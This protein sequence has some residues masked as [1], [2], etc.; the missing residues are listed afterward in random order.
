MRPVDDQRSRHLVTVS[1]LCMLTSA[2]CFSNGMVFAS[3]NSMYPIHLTFAPQWSV[4]PYSVS[5]TQ[6]PD[7]SVDVTVTAEVEG[8]MFRGF[9]L[10][11][12]NS[13]NMRAGSFVAVPPSA[14]ILQCGYIGGAVSHNSSDGKRK[15][16]ALWQPN[17]H[18]GD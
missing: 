7:G 1:L 4:P 3:C 13:S 5:A 16:T 12:R 6:N 14:Q 9:L 2:H 11:A 8:D 10:Q 15:V 18:R 17:G